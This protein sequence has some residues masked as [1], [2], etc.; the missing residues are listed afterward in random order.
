MNRDQFSHMSL[1]RELKENNP[2]DFRNYLRMTD[3][4]FQVLLGAVRPYIEKQNTILRKA[5]TAEQR[6][7]ATLRYLATGRSLQDLKFTTGIS[8]QAL[9]VIIP[10]T[11]NAIIQ[12]LQEEYIKVYIHVL[13]T[14]VI[15]VNMSIL[16]A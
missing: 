1:L 16:F 4:C 14:N 13:Q 9:G 8:P 2:D 5:I 12:V 7:I 15:I 10:E 6:L 3:E 11:C